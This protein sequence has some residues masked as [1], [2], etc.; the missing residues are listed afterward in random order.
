[1]VFFLHLSLSTQ[2][3]MGLAVSPLLGSPPAPISANQQEVCSV[4]HATATEGSPSAGH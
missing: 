2:S 1:L 4:A 3:I